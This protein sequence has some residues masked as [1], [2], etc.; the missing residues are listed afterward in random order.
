MPGSRFMST[1]QSGVMLPGRRNRGRGGFGWRARLVFV[2]GAALLIAGCAAPPTVHGWANPSGLPAAATG[3]F[4]LAA[5]DDPHD[6]LFRPLVTQR[7]EQLGYSE[8][9]DP[10]YLVDIAVALRSRKIGFFIPQEEGDRTWI[11]QPGKR[12]WFQPDH[13]VTLRIRFFDAHSGR[14]AMEAGASQDV[15]S[16]GVAGRAQD[17]VDA[18]L[19]RD[20]RTQT[21]TVRN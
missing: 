11:G 21:Q 15:S 2:S 3:T 16:D 17:L 6:A 12:H 5:D 7:L 13:V 20:P 14:P 1:P 9:A 4:A 18:A 10:D 19:A 8:A